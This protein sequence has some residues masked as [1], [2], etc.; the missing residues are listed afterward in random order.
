MV[1]QHGTGAGT[2]RVLR[3]AREG[4]TLP[5]EFDPFEAFFHDAPPEVVVAL[6][7][8][9]QV[10]ERLEELRSA[11]ILQSPVRSMRPEAL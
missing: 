3:Y 5:H 9:A 6:S 4:M 10:A 7:R 11:W 8:P 2:G 1:G